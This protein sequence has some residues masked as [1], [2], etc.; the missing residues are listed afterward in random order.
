MTMTEH[1]RGVAVCVA[2]VL[3]GGRSRRMG[4]PKAL[5]TLPDGRTL[6]EH[7]VGIAS[8]VAPDVVILGTPASLPPTLGHLP[9]LDDAKPDG[10]PLAGLCS[11]LQYAHDR[12]GLLL[13][14]DMPH[15]APDIL[16]RILSSIDENIDAVA[17]R[18]DVTRGTCHA[19]CALYHP[20]ILPRALDELTRG[21]AS[22]QNLLARVRLAVLQPDPHEAHLLT[23]L[24][25]PQDHARALRNLQNR[26]ITRQPE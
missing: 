2:G 19:C 13:A 11:L 10:G 5:L 6:I 18:Q 4:R 25:T 7:V 26:T 3:A 9:I 8:A 20:R 16:H 15:L 23:N 17:F 21:Q 24:N 14:C 12:W 1:S 22:L